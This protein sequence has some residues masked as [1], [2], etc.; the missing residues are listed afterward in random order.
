MR[1]VLI[2]VA[3]AAGALA[4]YGIG[5]AVGERSFP[6]ATLAINVVGSFVLALLLTVAIARSWSPDVVVPVGV[7]LLGAFTTFSTFSWDALTMGRADRYGSA[8]TYVLASV[9][10]ALLAAFLGFRTGEAL[11]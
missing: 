8:T 11:G 2:G 1:L 10:L 7:G 9:G 6:W 4:R 5:V 3:G